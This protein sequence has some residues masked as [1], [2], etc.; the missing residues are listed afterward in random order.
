MTE[1]E[2]D[3]LMFQEC[4]TVSEDDIREFNN[5]EESNVEFSDRFQVRMNRIFREQAG[6]KRVPYP[7]VD[8]RFERIR[9]AFR[10]RI[11]I[12]RHH[13]GK[14]KHNTADSTQ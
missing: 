6:I 5:I 13:H 7:E 4:Q 8:T 9:S 1:K 2:F 12:Y 14:S 10:R 11:L 3:D